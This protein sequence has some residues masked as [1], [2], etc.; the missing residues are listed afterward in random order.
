MSRVDEIRKKHLLANESGSKQIEATTSQNS[1]E[2]PKK[3]G[4]NSM[5]YWK[6]RGNKQVTK[7]NNQFNGLLEEDGQNSINNTNN[8]SNYDDIVDSNNNRNR[9]ED[10][11]DL[12]VE[13]PRRTG[14]NSV[15]KFKGLLEEP[16][17]TNVS[18]RQVNSNVQRK[19]DINR[20]VRGMDKFDEFLED[21]PGNNNN[22]Y[23]K[24]VSTRSRNYNDRNQ[25]PNDNTN[26]NNDVYYQ[27]RNRDTVDMQQNTQIENTST[28]TF[29]DGMTERAKAAYHPDIREKEEVIDSR[30]TGISVKPIQAIERSGRTD[31]VEKMESFVEE[32]ATNNM[33]AIT[34]DSHIVSAKTQQVV[35][36]ITGAINKTG[37]M[38][39]G[40]GSE[41]I[42]SQLISPLSSF[43][44]ET[45]E[46]VIVEPRV[47]L[48]SDCDYVL[49]Y[50]PKTVCAV[51][52][53]IVEAQTKDE[54]KI[55]GETYAI[56]RKPEYNK[57][58]N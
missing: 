55:D 40:I 22:N 2:I 12:N 4:Y 50:V 49:A 21:E 7:V 47:T 19:Q 10:R 56:V 9:R 43:S 14:N 1:T 18:N 44:T 58:S 54:F 27:E 24:E 8:N 45:E 20:D 26:Y 29:D 30:N 6:H 57:T 53:E 13:V 5:D 37:S 38:R 23:N 32:K 3:L 36:T 15:D 42:E 52:G 17:H 11:G 41:E 16:A 25:N 31:N 48:R 34:K 46:R 28:H 35:S 51:I 33:P 39:G